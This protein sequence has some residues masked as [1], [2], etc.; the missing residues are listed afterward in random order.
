VSKRLE[1]KTAFITGAA[2]G[3][4]RAHA[5]RFAQEGADVIMIDLEKQ[6]DVNVEY[7]TGTWQEL[8]ETARLVEREDRRAYAAIADVR[9]RVALQRVFDATAADFPRLDI[10]CS[11]AGITGH[12]RIL[13]VS[14]DEWDQFMDINLT[15]VFKAI[16]IFLPRMI[17]TGHGGS[18]IIT[19]SVA[20]IKGLPFFAAYS[21]AKHGC[22][23]LMRVLAQELAAESIR[24]NAVCPGPIA[25]PMT[26]NDL[27]MS[28]FT[29][30]QT[31]QVFQGS[32]AP[33]L[34]TP[35]GMEG[36]IEPENVTDAVLWLASDESRY[37]T[38][39]PIPVDAGVMVR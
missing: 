20:G 19:S 4:G 3:Q 17:E 34:P 1:G 21:A 5:V 26:M 22:I 12:G 9:D 6:G 32:F 13:E 30:D 2:H 31:M 24:V 11:N 36:F 35:D 37:V 18:I 23:G 39:L 25:T 10:I 33:M 27:I 14:Q 16:Q 28:L 15:G 29:D 38:G 7:A 8:Q